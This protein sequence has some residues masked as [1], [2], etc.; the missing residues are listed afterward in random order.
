MVIV[1]EV[2]T[3]KGMRKFADYPFRLYKNCPYYI[4][5]FRSDEENIADWLSAI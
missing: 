5:S 2:K 3:K 1:Q 4:P